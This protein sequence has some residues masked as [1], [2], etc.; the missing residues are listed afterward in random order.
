MPGTPDL[1]D[2]ENIPLKTDLGYAQVPWRPGMYVVKK[3]KN[4]EAPQEVFSFSIHTFSLLALHIFSLTIYCQNIL[5]LY[6]IVLKWDVLFLPII[7]NV[8]KSYCIILKADK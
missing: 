2:C 1:G 5:I 3:G 4:F 6:F 8:K 7:A